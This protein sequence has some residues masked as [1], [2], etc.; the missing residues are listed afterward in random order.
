MMTMR[1][2]P[3]GLAAFASLPMT[4]QKFLAAE[5]HSRQLTR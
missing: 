4:S 3:I 1:E 5:A 2:R